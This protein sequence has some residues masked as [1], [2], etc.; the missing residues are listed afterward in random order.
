MFSIVKICDF[1]V[2]NRLSFLF[3]YDSLSVLVS[4]KACADFTRQFKKQR[5]KR[6]HRLSRKANVLGIQLFSDQACKTDVNSY[7]ERNRI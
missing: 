1:V 7:N 2:L 5:T 3:Q 4:G 6:I